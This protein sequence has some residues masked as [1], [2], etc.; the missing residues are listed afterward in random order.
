MADDNFVI[1]EDPNQKEKKGLKTFRDFL[2]KAMEVINAD[3][4]TEAKLDK[5][6]EDRLGYD[7]R[8]SLTL[9]VCKV[10]M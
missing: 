1:V 2:K 10:D 3:K 4:E 8:I 5:A 9:L 7:G 6:F